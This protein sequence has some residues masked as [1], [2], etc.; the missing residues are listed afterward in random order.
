M[1]GTRH[2][3]RIKEKV[4]DMAKKLALA[5]DILDEWCVCQTEWIYL[6]NIFSA[7]DI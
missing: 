6:E 7:D 5:N 1:L 4:E 3:H 2:V